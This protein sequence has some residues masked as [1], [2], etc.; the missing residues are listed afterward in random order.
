MPTDVAAKVILPRP[1]IPFGIRVARRILGLY[2]F[3]AN[4]IPV[5]VKKTRQNNNL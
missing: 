5:R 3:Q 4:R 1:A 2:R